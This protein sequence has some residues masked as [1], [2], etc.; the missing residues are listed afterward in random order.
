M[1]I[2]TQGWKTKKEASYWATK[3]RKTGYKAR[4]SERRYKGYWR[5]IYQK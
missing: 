3:M 1:T 5:V 4:V 2:S